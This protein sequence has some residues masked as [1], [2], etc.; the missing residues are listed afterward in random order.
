V[1]V[2]VPQDELPFR[3]QRGRSGPKLY[4]D[5]IA[6][7]IPA[8]NEARSLRAVAT[9]CLSESRLVIVIDDASSDG[10]LETITDLPLVA[11][12]S[13]THLGKGGVM[14]LGFR[15][16][17]ELGAQ[18]VVTLDG[19]GQHDPHDIPAFV[20]A[21]NRHPGSLIIGA[22]L[23]AAERAPLARRFA[24]RIADFWI[25][26]AA[27]MVIRD[28]QCGQRLYPRELLLSVKP[29]AAPE[30]CFAFESEMLI[31]STWQGFGVVAV[32]IKARYPGDRRASHFRPA[33]DIW[34]I[35]RVVARK[36]F[37]GDRPQ[38]TRDMRRATDWPA[39]HEKNL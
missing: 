31:E 6:V 12:R 2:T 24:N 36:T 37:A 4:A 39:G 11:M 33:R 17:I 26:R 13:D 28:S 27:G 32:P 38:W 34:R 20:E 18:A 1:Q 8:R 35:A 23:Q 25:S 21:A 15:R 19:D 5:D 22:R 9:A 7:V 30:D 29:S 14:A 10:T 3:R 16:A